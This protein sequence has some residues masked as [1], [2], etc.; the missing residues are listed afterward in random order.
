MGIAIFLI[1]GIFTGHWTV[2]V[3]LGLVVHF[4]K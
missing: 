3:I 4:A 2:A 1:V